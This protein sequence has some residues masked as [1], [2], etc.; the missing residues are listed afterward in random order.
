[1]IEPVTSAV[2]YRSLTGSAS[3]TEYSAQP[4]SAALSATD[5]VQKKG[6]AFIGHALLK[7]EHADRMKQR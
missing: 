2:P 5:T 1:M 4:P 6:A 7:T 3:M